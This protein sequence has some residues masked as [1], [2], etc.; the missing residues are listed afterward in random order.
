MNSGQR[1][2]F[3]ISWAQTEVDGLRAG[4]CHL[5]AA[6][7]TWRW[8]GSAVRVDGPG[9]LLILTGDPDIAALRRRAA[10]IA[11]RLLRAARGAAPSR[12]R[13]MFEDDGLPPQG[14]TL[15][16]GRQRYDA[17]LLVPS[18]GGQP[19]VGFEGRMPPPDRDLWV[20]R[21]T[22]SGPSAQEVD[23]SGAGV[24]CF[25]AGTRI[26][27]P[28][29]ARPVETL[30][31]GE[32]V[33]TRDNGPQKVI[34]CGTSRLSGARL[35]AVPRLRPIRFRP[36]A[37]GIGRP[38]PDLLVSPRHRMLVRG[39][40]ARA[41]FNQDEVLV[42]AEDLVNGTTITVDARLAEVIY[43]HV[44]LERHEILWANGLE[45]ESFHPA[46]AA[47]DRL[48]PAERDSL[49]AALPHLASDPALYGGFA[50]RALT[51]PEA[52]ILRHAAA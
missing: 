39:A 3:V 44:L 24:I 19:L 12:S 35:H 23:G 15:T 4:P 31:P 11:R 33:L 5:I 10:P 46:V 45:T 38:D 43:V 20:V 50:R 34:W 7:T 51:A 48:A 13:E 29:G 28:A 16:D 49:V 26:A 32:A 30:A 1:G 40:A 36:G 17:R 21:S 8:T 2:T 22:L 37:F 18:A 42:A 14:F 6:G 9:S 47:L 52:A 41:L 27:T 25:A